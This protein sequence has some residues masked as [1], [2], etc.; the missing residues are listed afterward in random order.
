MKNK[1]YYKS[2]RYLNNV[3]RYT[4]IVNYYW[5]VLTLVRVGK[6]YN[7]TRERVRQIMECL[8]LN[9]KDIKRAI[10]DYKK[11][12]K[13]QKEWTMCRQCGDNFKISTRR[14]DGSEY[15]RICSAR[16]RFKINGYDAQRKSYQKHKEEY[17]ARNRKY[18]SEHREELK[19]YNRKYREE[20]KEIYYE[21]MKQRAIRKLLE[22]KDL[23]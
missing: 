17:K 22:P 12:Q 18:Y 9:A 23:I 5:K 1:K 20:N 3:D 13:I 16:L 4:A 10:A 6:K 2:K 14:K 21:Q 19:V 15:C 11:Y 8:G 7:L